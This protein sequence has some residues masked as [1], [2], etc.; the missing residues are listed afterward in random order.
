MK[1]YQKSTVTV[2]H[3]EGKAYRA[4]KL[5]IYGAMTTL[6]AGGTS[7]DMEGAQMTSMMKRP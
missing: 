7:G 6:T 1:E 5:Q 2:A 4:P 3:P